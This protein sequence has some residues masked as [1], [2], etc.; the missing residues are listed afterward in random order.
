MPPIASNVL[1]A[2]AIAEIQQWISTSLPARQDYA[3]WRVLKFQSANS[4]AGERTA[5]P[6]GDNATNEAEFLIGTEP[7]SGASFP[8]AQITSDG[9][10]L[11][12]S[13]N[14]PANRIVWI[15]TSTDLVTWSR[16]NVPGNNGLPGPAGVRTF[17]GSLALPRQFFRPVVIEN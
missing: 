6:D 10:T 2:G 11:T 1:D 8:N 3:A 16:W 14:L 4:G 12:V 15:E 5:N 17:T 13:L 7:N 9:S